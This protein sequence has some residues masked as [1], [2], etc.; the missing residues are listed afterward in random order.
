MKNLKTSIYTECR[1]ISDGSHSS[2]ALADWRTQYDNL[3][4]AKV[5]SIY[6]YLGNNLLP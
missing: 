5:S 2:S 4:F 6:F 1:D 3:G